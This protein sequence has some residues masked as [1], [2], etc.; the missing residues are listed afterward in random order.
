MYSML[1]SSSVTHRDKWQSPSEIFSKIKLNNK[2]H[3]RPGLQILVRLSEH[4]NESVAIREE[5][6]YCGDRR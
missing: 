5:S 4:V 3:V 1:T 2:L 6:W